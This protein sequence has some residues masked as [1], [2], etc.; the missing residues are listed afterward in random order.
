MLTYSDQKQVREIVRE[1]L[2]PLKKQLDKVEN[3]IDKVLSIVTRT[4]QEHTLTQT[5][6]TQHDKRLRKIEYKLKITSPTTS[7]LA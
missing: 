5:K 7:V 4:D 1:E 3:N 2:D 6:V